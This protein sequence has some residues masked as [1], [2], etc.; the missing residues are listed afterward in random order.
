MAGTSTYAGLPAVA[1]IAE[2]TPAS[3]L[4][5]RTGDVGGLRKATWV[6]HLAALDRDLLRSSIYTRPAVAGLDTPRWTEWTI[7][8]GVAGSLPLLGAFRLTNNGTWTPNAG[9]HAVACIGVGQDTIAGL[10]PLYGVEGRVNAYG[11]AQYIGALGK[12]EYRRTTAELPAAL[13]TTSAGVHAE[14][15]YTLADGVTPLVVDGLNAIAI[16]ATPVV[17]GDPLHR[18]S[19][20]GADRIYTAAAIAA[21]ATDGAL[22]VPNGGARIGG[23]LSLGGG[24]TAGGGALFG[25]A[26]QVA[27]TIAGLLNLSIVNLDAGNSSGS[28]MAFQTDAGTAYLGLGS[29]AFALV[30]GAAG[31]LFGYCTSGILLTGSTTTVDAIQTSPGALAGVAAWKLGTQRSATVSLNTAAYVE[32]EIGGSL[33]KLALVN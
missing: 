4:A 15:R 10:L 29:A 22:L 7:P 1:D 16:L 9:D 17:G 32:V 11:T 21:T 33:K 28:S 3:L 31:K 19:L 2:I 26:I 6:Q 14:A 5:I 23:G 18:Y 25:A 24:I 27:Q 20:K 13:G 12:L 30:P 8:S